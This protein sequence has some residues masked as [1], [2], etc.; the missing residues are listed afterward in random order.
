[1]GRELTQDPQSHGL[2]EEDIIHIPGL[3][4]R[5]VRLEDGQIARYVTSGETG[6]AVILLHGG[7]EGSSGTAGWRF[8]APFLGANGFRVFAPDRPG[9]GQS[10]TSKVEY[11]RADAYAQVEFVRKFAD[12]LCLDKFFISGNSAGC[13]VSCNVVITHPDRILGVAFIAGGIG[14]IVEAERVPPAQGKFT[15]NPAYVSPGFDGTNDSMRVL[16]EGIIY[17]AKAIWPELI[18][19]RVIAANKQREARAKAGVERV[20]LAASTDPNLRQLFST[21][22]RLDKLTVPMI[23][24]YGLQD[25]L[26]PVDNGFNQEDVVPNIQ[27]FYP[28]ECGHQGQTDQPDMFNQVFLEFFRDGK[29]S[30][31][32][33]Q[34]AGVSR[35]RP[36]NGNVVEEPA[37]GFP[38]PVPEAYTDINSLRAALG[39][40]TANR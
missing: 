18:E 3:L 12:A 28:D 20:S 17:E 13:T 14:D 21:K 9:F 34:W 26:S 1:M 10:D 15:P 19:M 22:N 4:S 16:M 37:G 31:K 8:M 5:S 35:R 33:A 23:Y 7:I 27:Y 36:I 6:P 24:M 11:L 40:V 32:T 29:V 2:T 25:V 30:W 39:P 38:K